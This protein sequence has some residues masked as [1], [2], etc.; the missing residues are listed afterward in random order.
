[1][2]IGYCDVIAT[3]IMDYSTLYHVCAII[4]VTAY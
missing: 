1:M 4:V 3:D 2:Q